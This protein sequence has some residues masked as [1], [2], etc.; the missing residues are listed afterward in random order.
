MT[1]MLEK[2]EEERNSGLIEKDLV[3]KKKMKMV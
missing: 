1:K 2:D 3:K